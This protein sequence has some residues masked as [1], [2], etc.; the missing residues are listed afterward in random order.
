MH[1]LIRRIEWVLSDIPFLPSLIEIGPFSE[2]VNVFSLFRSNNHPLEKDMALHLNKLKSPLLKDT[3]CQS[4]KLDQWF[5]RRRFLKFIIGPLVLRKE[6]KMWKVYWQTDGQTTDD[7]RSEKL[8]WAKRK[9][10]LHETNCF[11]VNKRETFTK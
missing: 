3:L 4:L 8:R 2:L 7:R 11:Y 1:N 5:R 6:K 10:M 9:E